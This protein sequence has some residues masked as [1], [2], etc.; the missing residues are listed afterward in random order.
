MSIPVRAWRLNHAL[1]NAQK[2]CAL[3]KVGTILKLTESQNKKKTVLR[4]LLLDKET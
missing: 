3:T 4:K 1:R 2:V